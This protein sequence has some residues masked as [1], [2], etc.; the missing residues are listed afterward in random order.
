M[1]TVN[2]TKRDRK[3]KLKSGATVTQTRY[4]INFREPRTGKR[5]QLF[6]KRQKDAQAKRSEIEATVH[7]GSRIER[8]TAVTVRDAV[9]AWLA[10]RE[11]AI[12]GRTLEAYRYSADY[13][14]GPLLSG[15][16][17]QR[18]EFTQTGVKPAGTQLLPMLGDVRLQELTTGQ[19]RAWHKTVSDFVGYYSANRSR[20]HLQT[21]LALAAEDFNIRPPAMPVSLDRGRPKAK[22]AILT[23][24]QVGSLLQCARK[25]SGKAFYVA[26]PFLAGT[27]PSE[28]LG[29]LWDDIDFEHGVIHISRMQER[30]GELTEF[31][32]TLAGTREV[33][34]CGALRG[35]LREWR[36]QCPR[37]DG[38]LYRV[39]PGLGPPE[40]WPAVR[41]GGR[42][43]LYCNFRSRVWAPTLKRL[44]LPAVTPHSARH[45]FI[46][47]LQAQGIEVGL[48]AKI[49]GHANANVTLGHYTQAVR[50]AESAV[51]ALESAFT[52]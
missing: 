14:V 51:E 39:F 36:V 12:K 48:V 49:A 47:T 52:A 27:R 42:P 32:K 50:G 38:G 41:K 25:E 26:F 20:M 23:P 7:T 46:S 18:A 21:A 33:P 9:E 31:T 24:A 30:N 10:N 29:L 40:P 15:T 34:I 19:I 3:R 11:G 8:R 45:C 17:E 5:T 22:K 4:V 13:I 37:V 1:I 2:I 43:L 16:S 35:M 6:F 28:Q 44:G